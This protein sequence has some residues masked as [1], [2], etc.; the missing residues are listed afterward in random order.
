[1]ALRVYTY[2][3]CNTCRRALAFLDEHGVAYKDIPIRETPPTKA[4]L[5]RML[6]HVGGTVKR[7][8][9]IAG[10]DY[11]ALK[12]KDTL[13]GMPEAEVLKLLA[14]NGNL[15]RRPFAISSSTGVT[16]FNSEQWMEKFV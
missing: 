3:N 15:V 5:K 13:G 4:E 16:G 7:L 9:N 14:S 1:M 6:G 11:R 12:L 10:T 2:K 8:F